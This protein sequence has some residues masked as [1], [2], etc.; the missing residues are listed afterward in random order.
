MVL[1]YVVKNFK[2]RKIRTFLM[3][4]SL[5]VSTALIVTM[6]ATVE[7]VRRSNVD[8][9]SSSIGR[10]DLSVSKTDISADPFVEVTETSQRILQADREI[11]AVYPRFV[12][13]VEIAVQGEQTE[14]T[15]IARQPDEEIGIIDIVEGDMDLSGGG[16]ALFEDTADIFGLEVGDTIDIAYSFP[17]P[18]AEGE[19]TTV[20]VSERR[21]VGRFPVVAVVRQ[22]GVVG[23]FVRDGLLMD[24]DEVQSWLGLTN[25]ASTLIG[26]VNPALYEAGNSEDAALLVRDV[27]INVQNAL[28]QEYS[29]S[30]DKAAI[31]D[32]SA[33]AFLV[34]QALINTYGL[35]AFGIVGL[36]IHT[37]V[38]TNVQEQRREMAILRILGSLRNYLF[39]I[40][41]VEVAV[42]GLI[43]VSFGVVLGQALTQYGVI[44]F[45]ESQLAQDGL[46]VTIQ[47]VVSLNI[48]IP[49]VIAAFAVLF[50]SALKPAQDASKT[51]VMYAINPGV[52]DNI[53]LED[54]AELRE[55]R[56][57]VRFFIWGLVMV[58]AVALALGLDIVS[59]LGNPVLEATFFLGAILFMVLGVGLVF[60]IATRPLERLILLVIGLIAPRLTYFASRN[61]GRS[62]K[63]NA[64]ISL[65][66][67]FS[68]VLPSFLAT[69]NAIGVANIQTDVRLD[70]GAPIELN[71][72]T[73]FSEPGLEE[74]DWL[75]P[76]FLETELLAVDGV[77]DPVGISASYRADISDAVGMR[78]TSLNLYGV[79]SDLNE[80]LFED[81][82]IFSAGD[83]SA[84]E[85]IVTDDDAVIISEG[86]SELLA[87]QLG[88]TLKLKG[89]G[90]D[91]E[92][93]FEI[94]G[95]A[96]RLPGFS[97]F[98]RSRT[99]AQGGS[100][101]L[102]SLPA[103]YRISTD[104]KE[105][106]PEYDSNSITRI[107]AKV[108]PTA[109]ANEVS[110]VL[111]EEYGFRRGIRARVAEVSLERAQDEQRQTQVF[112]VVLTMISF[113]TA[114][115]GVFAVI[116]VTI[117][118]RRFEIGM[119]KAVGTRRRELSGMLV[120]ESITMTLSAALAGIIA[121]ASLGYLFAYIENVSSERPMIFAVDTTVMPFV[122]IMVVF[123]SIIGAVFSARRI[124]K[125]KAIEILRMS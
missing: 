68:G 104:L 103:Y 52:A 114:V 116:Y 123:A 99:T 47:P 9:L 16:V 50:L 39:S 85:R 105:A 55:Q 13:T 2:R 22:T 119:M 37:L 107:L 27:V 1:N 101:A 64:L 5:M 17:K 90:L 20:G 93:E 87:V 48:I 77:S 34:L 84:L 53:Q 125:F 122:V 109:D 46:T 6:S 38:M 98:G 86:L 42:I 89:E 112:L 113:T 44:P 76:S 70:M 95:I 97:G 117:Y 28:G 88:G 66:V 19:A 35:M 75:K 29:Y 25:R 124:I 79:T 11:T 73:R 4:M 118:S 18:R 65:L 51:K 58:S 36:L 45:I 108:E 80:V 111:R 69:Q 92:E 3:V 74:L 41:M 91:H 10:Y 21:V 94:V 59:T 110:A 31:L 60:L 43:G 72:S 49:A 71:V 63:R 33:Q 121:G 40:V 82:I 14:A 12:S 83:R 67:L 32:A 106:I 56:P 62:N 26:L 23:T 30:L 102:I 96:R 81:M 61:V 57:N 115:F 8:L 15:L 100:S 24:F 120:I 7:T 78:E 54:L